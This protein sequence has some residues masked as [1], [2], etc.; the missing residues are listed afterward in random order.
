MPKKPEGELTPVEQL[1]LHALHTMPADVVRRLDLLAI[2]VAVTEEDSEIKQAALLI[3]R[4][5]A[6]HL[7]EVQRV[8]QELPLKF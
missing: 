8:Q 2:I 4:H 3:R 5:L 1:A 6:A 7:R